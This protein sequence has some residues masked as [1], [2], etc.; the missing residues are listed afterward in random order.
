MTTATTAPPSTALALIETITAVELFKPGALD[1]ILER[2]EKEA[3]E[4]AAS[5][6]I[7]TEVNRKALA[8]LA[9]K[10]ARSKTY[11]DDCGKDLTEDM[12]K[13]VNAINAERARAREKMESL[14]DRVRKPLT[15]WEDV[16][17]ARVACHEE[18]LK[19]MT[20]LSVTRGFCSV[21]DIEVRIEKA[22]G[23]HAR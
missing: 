19:I 5:L 2:I 14:K 7:S 10:I 3:L 11:I 12:R 20:D 18:A 6:E 23:L 9:Y 4:Q 1:P 21:A 13:S 15:D 22:V 16:E 8:S 17:K